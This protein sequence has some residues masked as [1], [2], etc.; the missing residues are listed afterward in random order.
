V[1][2]VCWDDVQAFLALLNRGGQGRFRLPSEAEW[3]F[4]ARSGGKAERFSGA[5]SPDAV[6]WFEANS[7][8]S[9]QP[10]GRKRP[11]GLGFYDMSGNV[12][13]WCLDLFAPDAYRRHPLHDPLWQEAGPDRVIRGG[14][15]NLDAWSVRCARRF[16]YPPDFVGPALGFRVLMEL[17]AAA[18]GPSA[19]G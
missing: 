14:S 18:G 3:E 2:Q 8:G 12:W 19:P 7:G 13:E 1:E 15:W 5:D 9:T 4:A 11:N 17:P 10:V 16:G 6:A